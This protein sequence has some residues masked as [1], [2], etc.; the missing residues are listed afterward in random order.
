MA[1]TLN[2]LECDPQCGFMV[3]SHDIKELTDIALKHAKEAHKMD[4]TEADI[5]AMIKPA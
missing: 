4:V 3:R 1:D 2:K 5:K